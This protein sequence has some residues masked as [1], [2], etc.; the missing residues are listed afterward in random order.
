MT[1][2]IRPSFNAVT[3]DSES[4]G[5]FLYVYTYCKVTLYISVK[6]VLVCILGEC[7]QTKAHPCGYIGFLI[8]EYFPMGN[9][10]SNLWE[11][12]R[13]N[14]CNSEIKRL[15]AEMKKQTTKEDFGEYMISWQEAHALKD[16]TLDCCNR[17]L[18]G[19]YN[20]LYQFHIVHEMVHLDV[21]GAQNYV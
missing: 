14:N 10:S 2:V 13:L 17:L 9:I 3:N 12:R 1:W 7:P 19:I 18:C 4:V 6:L 8:M 20:S 11:F 16:K 5:M 15:E 21:K